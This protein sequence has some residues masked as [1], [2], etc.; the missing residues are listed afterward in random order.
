MQHNR[1]CTGNFCVKLC[2][3]LRL[4]LMLSVA[5]KVLQRVRAAATLPEARAAAAA[6]ARLTA[7]TRASLEQHVRS[8]YVQ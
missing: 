5:A 3:L 2:V 1:V 4:T 7:A 8:P 6:L